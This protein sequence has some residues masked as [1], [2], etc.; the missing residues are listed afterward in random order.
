[1]AISEQWKIQFCDRVVHFVAP[2]TQ[3][4]EV[5]CHFGPT[6]ISISR[7]KSV[8]TAKVVL[9]FIKSCKCAVEILFLTLYRNDNA[10]NAYDAGGQ[11]AMEENNEW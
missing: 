8:P 5:V 9:I 7:V 1:V 10:K 3:R 4:W 6:E 11:I 2:E